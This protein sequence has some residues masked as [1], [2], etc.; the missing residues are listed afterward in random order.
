MIYSKY[1]FSFQLAGSWKLDQSLKSGIRF[2][3]TNYSQDRVIFAF[4]VNMEIKYIGVCRSPNTTL[5]DRM[6]RFQ[7]MAGYCTNK[8][9]AE[10]IRKSLSNGQSVTIL[11]WQPDEGVKIIGE[12]VDQM[13][14]LK[15]TLIRA[16]DT[17]WNIRS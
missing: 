3:L 1:H 4:T 10:L 6:Y 8:R 13:L 14:G 16:L 5:F 7:S 9:I 17:E 11:A 2:S 15:N 12:E